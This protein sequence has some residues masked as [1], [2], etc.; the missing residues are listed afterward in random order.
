MIELYFRMYTLKGPRILI[1]IYIF[2]PSAEQLLMYSAPYG[3]YI[4]A[5]QSRCMYDSIKLAKACKNLVSNQSIKYL[6]KDVYI[7]TYIYIHTNY[8]G[9]C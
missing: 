4:S 1:L 6:R 8:S 5:L 2:G 3:V 9:Q 7:H